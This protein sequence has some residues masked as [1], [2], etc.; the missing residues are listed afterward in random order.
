MAPPYVALADLSSRRRPLYNGLIYW[1]MGYGLAP[2]DVQNDAE[3]M[4]TMRQLGRNMAFVL[5]SQFINR[6][7]LQNQ[8]LGV[9]F[10]IV[11]KVSSA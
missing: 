5:G 4:E 7:W 8:P 9:G 10:V 11:K 3:G 2:G 6:P 1:N